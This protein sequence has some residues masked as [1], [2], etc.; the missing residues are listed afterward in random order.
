MLLWRRSG[1]PDSILI[2]AH[3]QALLIDPQSQELVEKVLEGSGL[4]G[5]G[6]IPLSQDLPWDLR[7]SQSQPRTEGL[8]QAALL[9]LNRALEQGHLPRACLYA[10]SYGLQSEVCLRD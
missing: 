10:W 2:D 8:D 9:A 7:G 5:W 6:E 4:F 1:S 3:I